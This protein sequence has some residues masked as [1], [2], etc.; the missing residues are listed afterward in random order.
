MVW[1]QNRV[2]FVSGFVILEHSESGDLQ[3]S[4]VTR[5]LSAS[6]FRD[7]L[8]LLSFYLPFCLSH[9][10]NNLVWLVILQLGG[11]QHLHFK[12]FV[13]VRATDVVSVLK[14]QQITDIVY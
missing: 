10:H 6:C 8:S 3:F 14:V 2:S 1:V 11:L 12:S 5:V 13:R 9:W 4:E 7:H